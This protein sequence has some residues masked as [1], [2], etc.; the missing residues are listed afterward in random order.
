MALIF[1][2][3]F[4]HRDPTGRGMSYSTAVTYIPGRVGGYALQAG[5]SSATVTTLVLPSTV[6]TVWA[7]CA[8]RK[9]NT[10]SGATFSCEIQNAGG[11]RQGTVAVEPNGTITLRD[12]SGVV[13]ATS[14][15]LSSPAGW[16]RL[17]FRVTALQ[18]GSA[19]VWLDGN[20]VCEHTGDYAYASGVG[21]DAGAT[22]IRFDIGRYPTSGGWDFDDV[23]VTD[24]TGPA[25]YNTRLPDLRIETLVPS[26]NGSASQLVGSDGNQVDNF[27]LV[28][29]LPVS[30][31]DYVTSGVSGERDLYTHTDLATPTGQVWGVQVHAHALKTDAGVGALA[32]LTKTDGVERKQTAVGLSTSPGWISGAIQTD[33]PDATPWTVAKV[34]ASEFGVE[35]A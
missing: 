3:G 32:P 4:E 13:V 12:Q 10:T 25:P 5:T 8:I 2:D 15:V 28:D 19:E 17:D 16:F 26:A 18:A 31:A 30:T 24:T 21:A 6:T 14:P 20:K 35:V 1:M 29:E 7:S 33:A 27:A 34:N 11:Q 9:N 22:R 23:Y